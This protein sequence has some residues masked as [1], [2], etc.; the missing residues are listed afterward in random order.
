MHF[1]RLQGHR[2][3][4]VRAGELHGDD[5]ARPGHRQRSVAGKSPVRTFLKRV[6]AARHREGTGL[7]RAVDR[8]RLVGR[9]GSED[10]R[11]ARVEGR[12]FARQPLGVGPGRGVLQDFPGVRAG[13]A[14]PGETHRIALLEIEGQRVARRIET[15]LAAGRLVVLHPD[16]GNLTVVQGAEAEARRTQQ[17]HR[18]SARPESGKRGQVERQHRIARP[19][20][21]RSVHLVESLRIVLQRIV[22]HDHAAA[23]HQAARKLPRTGRA[24]RQRLFAAERPQLQG[25]S[26]K[27]QRHGVRRS[28]IRRAAH[29]QNALAGRHD[30]VERAQVPRQNLRP[31]PVVDDRNP[32][33]DIAGVRVAHAGRRR[34]RQ[35]RLVHAA[36]PGDVVVVAAALQP[37][38]RHLLHPELQLR[39]PVGVR[40]AF[41]RI[42]L[43]LHRRVLQGIGVV[44]AQDEVLPPGRSAAVVEQRHRPVERPGTVQLENPVHIIVIVLPQGKR[45]A[46][47]IPVEGI[48]RH[49]PDDLV[50][51]NRRIVR[52]RQ[53]ARPEQNLRRRV[54]TFLLRQVDRASVQIDVELVVSKRNLV[55]EIERA[56][57][58][59]HRP[60]LAAQVDALLKNQLPVLAHRHFTRYPEIREL[61]RRIHT[62]R[63]GPPQVPGIGEI[64]VLGTGENEPA[65]LFEGDGRGAVDALGHLGAALVALH[66]PHQG[67]DRQGRVLRDRK[68][69][70]IGKVVA[71]QHDAAVPLN[72]E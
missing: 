29:V 57:V 66:N 10:D 47:G 36:S 5:R 54:R 37:G 34:D 24:R 50:E 15:Q 20:G 70:Q 26:V 65:A 68:A 35:R 31:G 42:G 23:Q 64:V 48:R 60:R 18:V 30:R 56:A 19:Q 49:D 25:A 62:D 61:H 51:G 41:S 2:P 4:P 52:H 32:I 7:H 67:I 14:G 9:I 40:R 33:P 46:R 1:A 55:G 6:A 27:I 43:Q 72:A 38:N 22:R 28:E 3:R 45:L 17:L 58:D 59:R 21:E 63:S 12:L 53:L 39:G 71:R 44:E 16:D 11:V 69:A 8:H 13:G